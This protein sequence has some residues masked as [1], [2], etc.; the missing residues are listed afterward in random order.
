MTLLPARFHALRDRVLSATDH[1]FAEPVR[2]SFMSGGAVDAA[3][4]M[5]QIEAIL[6]VDHGSMAAPSGKATDS[7]WLTRMGAEKGTLHIDRVKYPDVLVK[8]GDK[9]KA[10]SR[11]G[12]PWFEVLTV[13]E[14]SHTRLVLH[15]G[16]A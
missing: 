4:P 13:D 5:I 2:L 8:Q 3:R 7:A 11:P 12:E 10:L 14:R 9:V 15:L 6:R 16:E 1:V